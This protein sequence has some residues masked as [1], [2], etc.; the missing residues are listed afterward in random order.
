MG[1]VSDRKLIGLYSLGLLHI[2][3]FGFKKIV[4]V[5]E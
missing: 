3:I 5:H 1:L 4:F 2:C